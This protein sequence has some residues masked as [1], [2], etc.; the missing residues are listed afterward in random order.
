MSLHLFPL[1]GK[2]MLHVAEDRAQL[3]A[4]GCDTEA[5][6]ASLDN[7]RICSRR[8]HHCK[9]TCMDQ[10][11]LRCKGCIIVPTLHAGCMQA[12]VIEYRCTQ[13]GKQTNTCG[14]DCESDAVCKTHP[15]L[16]V[17]RGQAVIVGLQQL[18]CGHK[19]PLVVLVGGKLVAVLL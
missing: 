16:A 9:Y 11:V 10:S 1:N 13:T 17:Q 18:R 2:R 12:R 3:V 15:H 19:P 7:G 5:K 8:G 4:K 14:S 6:P